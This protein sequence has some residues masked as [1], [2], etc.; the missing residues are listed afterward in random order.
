MTPPKT[1]L[2]AFEVHNFA[3]FERERIDLHPRVTVLVG[4]NDVGK[5]L[6]L[7][8]I[9][10]YGRIQ[11][12]GF[13]GPLSY[14]NFQTTGER[15]TTFVAEWSMDGKRWRHVLKLHADTPEERVEHGDRF[16]SWN[17]RERVLSTETGEYAAK[18]LD[19]YQ[20]LSRIELA[21]WKLDTEIAES[22]YKPL[23]VVN[24]FGTPPAYLFEPSALGRRAPLDLEE[25]RRNGFGWSLWLQAIV[26]RRNDDLTNLEATVRSLFPFFGR[27]LVRENRLK[28][29]QEISEL[30]QPQTGDA[31][32]LERA[33][34]ANYLFDMLKQQA[35]F[36]E[37]FI[38]PRNEPAG[39]NTR[40]STAQ[41]S[42]G[43]LLT[44]AHLSLMYASEGGELQLIEEP[45]NGLNPKITL[46]M[47]RA[48]LDV[49]SERNKQLVL[50]T[51]NAWWLDL[52]PEDAI[53][54]IVRD[55]DGAHIH[56]PDHNGLRRLREDLDIYP[57]EVM[58][59]HGPEALVNVGKL[60][61]ELS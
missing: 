16:W 61:D 23:S 7:E 50:T 33:E 45:E 14:T 2:E 31:S 51:H 1:F 5:S 35:S 27:V 59:I 25:P 20:T 52:V 34:S 6:L 8:A 47:I 54:V 57:S 9:T 41:V 32:T 19:R 26:N 53:R 44:L 28:I 30:G 40:F 3:L 13:R 56:R 55:Q 21:K 42:S 18:E 4:Q 29:E 58:S 60:Q 22:V 38:E 36:R 39:E 37:V 10:L 48:L 49:V 24:S 11:K 43:I 15:V 46:E 17:P 12:A